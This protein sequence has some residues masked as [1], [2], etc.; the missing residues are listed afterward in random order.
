VLV[1]K[2]A[3]QIKG[4]GNSTDK[5]NYR[6]AEKVFENPGFKDDEA[7]TYSA[8]I[9]PQ[10][11][12]YGV[13]WETW[14]APR[15][16]RGPDDKLTVHQYANPKGLG[17]QFGISRKQRFALKPVG[18]KEVEA[19]QAAIADHWYEV[20]LVCKAGKGTLYYRDVTAGETEFNLTDVQAV[21]LGDF[22]PSQASAWV[23]QGKYAGAYDNFAWG[24]VK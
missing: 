22:K 7:V 8:W 12:A 2:G 21:P 20:R 5:K 13:V 9:Q 6:V 17:P 16:P 4:A 24:V 10:K 1:A 23:F 11:G 3:A 14:C 15:I 18:G 19:G